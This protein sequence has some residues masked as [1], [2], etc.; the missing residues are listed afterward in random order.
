MWI[1]KNTWAGGAACVKHDWRK[2]SK[3][4]HGVRRYVRERHE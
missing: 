2:E 3:G 1:F 4:R